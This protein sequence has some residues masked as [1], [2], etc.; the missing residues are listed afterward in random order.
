MMLNLKVS[1]ITINTQQIC[2]LKW[3]DNKSVDVT[4]LKGKTL[5]FEGKDFSFLFD[6]FKD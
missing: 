5:S 4:F 2:Y 3:I 6:F 1:K